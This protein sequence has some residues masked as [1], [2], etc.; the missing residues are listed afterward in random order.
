MVCYGIVNP[1]KKRHYPW[2]KKRK[3]NKDCYC[4]N[5]GCRGVLRTKNFVKKVIIK[6]RV[7]YSHCLVFSTIARISSLSFMIA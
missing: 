3:N 7:N 6:D 1:K 2:S 4:W 5:G